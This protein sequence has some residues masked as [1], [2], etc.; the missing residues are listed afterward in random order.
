MSQSEATRDPEEVVRYTVNTRPFTTEAE[1]L[2]PREIMSLAGIDPAK[3]YLTLIHGR[4]QESFKDKPDA[5][6][7]MKD[8]MTFVSSSIEPTPVS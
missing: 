7:E 4:H 1:K 2:T 5:E 3:N 6:I 8:G